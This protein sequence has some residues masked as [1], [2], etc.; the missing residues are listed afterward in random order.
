MAPSSG[1]KRS[2]TT[3]EED[4]L[5]DENKKKKAKK[6][7][8]TTTSKEVKSGI[9]S[10]RG[11][12]SEKTVSSILEKKP[13][14]AKPTTTA[15]GGAKTSRGNSSDRK[16]P[17]SQANNS[18]AN[19]PRAASKEKSPELNN[20]DNEEG[21]GKRPKVPPLKIVLSGNGNGSPP[22]SGSAAGQVPDQ[23]VEKKIASPET[24]SAQ[25]KDENPSQEET[26]ASNSKQPEEKETSKNAPTATASGS[27]QPMTESEKASAASRVTRS[28]A[29]QS[30][31]GPEG[32]SGDQQAGGGNSSEASSTNT[33]DNSSSNERSERSSN[34]TEYHV[35]KRKLRSQVDDSQAGPSTSNGGKTG[36]NS[37]G[38]NATGGANVTGNEPLND[39][40]KFLNLRKTVEGRRKNLFPVQP[41]PPQGFKDYLMNKKTYLLQSNAHERLRSMPMI[42]P[43]PS[44]EGP[45]RQLFVEQ[46]KD[47]YQLRKRHLVE[48]EKLVLNV[49]QEIIRVHG[50][51][52]RA[53]ANQPYPYSVC[54]ILKDEEIYT[55]IDTN[56]DEKTRDIRSRYNGRLFLSWLQDV[57]D[58]WEKIKVR[59]F[60]LIA[61]SPHFLK[62]LIFNFSTF[63]KTIDFSRN[64]WSYVT[65]M[66]PSP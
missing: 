8:T 27:T 5:E 49:E 53:L 58:K 19:S 10:T 12:S 22:N 17:T 9:R 7:E 23:P 39:I 2:S 32:A 40:Q 62:Q 16:S 38:N 18:G 1:E 51:A 61:I 64:K 13:E 36:N 35:K 4:L 3:V 33:Q 29:N 55:P 28:R 47:R 25:V 56:L 45:L 30:T 20:S 60:L 41:K 65:T 48:K 11:N 24:S 15:S 44:L 59:L 31:P 14:P 26:S 66:K 46:E 50:R 43:P 42:Q 54:T 63:F 52:A 21:S 57:D 34:Y 6:E 37:A